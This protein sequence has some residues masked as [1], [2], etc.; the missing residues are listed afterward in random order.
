MPYTI[1]KREVIVE[2]DSVEDLARMY[3]VMEGEKEEVREAVKEEAPRKPAKRGRPKIAVG[4]WT[5]QTVKE[6]LSGLPEGAK[7]ILSYL[8]KER[9]EV[10]SNDLAKWMGVRQGRQLVSYLNK[11]AWQ[12][13]K[14]SLPPAFAKRRAVRKGKVIILYKA[15]P[16]FRKVYEQA[17]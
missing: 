13:K 17:G 8:A 15:D 12:L 14:L 11:I 7:K 6:F 3:K 10:S 5:P 16:K 1:K 2:V 4:E 9:G